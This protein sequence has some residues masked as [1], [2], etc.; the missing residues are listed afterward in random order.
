MTPFFLSAEFGGPLLAPELTDEKDRAKM[1]GSLM[2][3]EAES[4]EEVRKIVESDI[5]YTSGVVRLTFPS[6]TIQ[7]ISYFDLDLVGQGKYLYLTFCTVDAL[8]VELEDTAMAGTVI[9]VIVTHT[10]SQYHHFPK[11][12]FGVTYVFVLPRVLT[13]AAT[14]YA[15]VHLNICVESSMT[16]T[17]RLGCSGAFLRAVLG[18]K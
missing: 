8:A 14:R 15:H 17:W 3:C 12:A 5:Y 18:T 6:S 13:P 2:F 9:V 1:I 16:V 10:R 4:I 11:E 7:S